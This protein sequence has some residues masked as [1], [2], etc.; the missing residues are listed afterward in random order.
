MEFVK[1]N[2][3][4][5]SVEAGTSG[6]PHPLKAWTFLCSLA[7]GYVGWVQNHVPSIEKGERPQTYLLESKQRTIALACPWASCGPVWVCV[8]CSHVARDDPATSSGEENKRVGTIPGGE[9]W[10]SPQL[11]LV[12]KA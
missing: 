8:S 4:Q 7:Q 5:E 12:G 11:H 6:T 3:K 2:L 10:E 9:A 1:K